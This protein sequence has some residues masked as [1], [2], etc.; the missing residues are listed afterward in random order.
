MARSILMLSLV[1]SLFGSTPRNLRLVP[2]VCAAQ[3]LLSHEPA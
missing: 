2:A 1:E 3:R